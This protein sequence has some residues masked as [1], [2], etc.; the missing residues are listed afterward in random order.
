MGGKK[1]AANHEYS[2]HEHAMSTT[3]NV[4]PRTRLLLEAGAL[5]LR[6]VGPMYGFFGVGLVLYFA[7]QGAG[8]LLWRVMVNLA[9]LLVAAIGGWLAI[10]WGGVLK[11]VFAMQG[12][13]LLVYG[14]VIAAAIAGGTWFGRVG[15]PTS[16]AALLR[17]VA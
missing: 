4:D 13:A 1:I 6:S 12:V 8:R 5:Y 2:Q 15:W 14:V 7:S 17:R 10:R 9:R 11:E 3:A 16:T